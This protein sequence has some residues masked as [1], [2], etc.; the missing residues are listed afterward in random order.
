[1]SC[2]RQ[3]GLLK[4]NTSQT[5]LFNYDSHA[6]RMMIFLPGSEVSEFQWLYIKTRI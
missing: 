4:I 3:I 2:I 1:M 6:N 5:L